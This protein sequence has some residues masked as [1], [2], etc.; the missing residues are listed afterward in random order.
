MTDQTTTYISLPH[1]LIDGQADEALSANVL[2]ALVE[3]TVDG[4]F[5]CEI[6]LNNF[7]ALPSGEVGYLYFDR[8]TLDFGKAIALGLGPGTPPKSVFEGYI[9]ALEGEY[10]V[11]GGGRLIVLAEDRLQD[12]RMTRRTRS[13]EKQS[14]ADII[15]KIANEHKLTPKI[16]LP[17]GPHESVAQVN[18]SDLAFIRERAHLAGS[19]VRVRGKELHVAPRAAGKP[20]DLAYGV[21]LMA[22][23]ARADLAQQ[24]TDLTVSGW[25][26]AAKSEIKET[27]KPALISDELNGGK[28]GGEILK[29]AFGA[30][31]ASVVHTVPLTTSE[32]Q[33]IAKARYRE[34]A[35]RFVTGSG[36]TDGSA[37]LRVGVTVKLSGLGSMFDGSYY[38]VR[39]R[40]TYNA[41]QGFRTEF[42]VERPGIG[43]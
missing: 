6:I 25:D 2:A 3:E 42:D 36:M 5:R 11:G 10:P 19:E 22:F 24:C 33:A 16:D 41:E 37:D 43:A 30:R 15:R 32:A 7:G 13:F 35:R 9:T 23:S 34:R 38:V 31:K 40:H 4:L 14:D 12:L 29:Q 26:V 21:S 8:R 1:V 28:G 20:I 27:V 39:V 18:L 17:G